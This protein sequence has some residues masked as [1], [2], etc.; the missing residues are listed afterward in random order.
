MYA[1][2]VHLQETWCLSPFYTEHDLDLD[3]ARSR[4]STEPNS[5]RSFRI[6]S[7]L[8]EYLHHDVSSMLGDTHEVLICQYS[9]KTDKRI[10]SENQKKQVSRLF[11][12][13]AKMI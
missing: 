4:E 13:S 8:N 11:P 3:K 9:V 2:Q 6:Y 1:I 10:N 7:H 12:V 5:R